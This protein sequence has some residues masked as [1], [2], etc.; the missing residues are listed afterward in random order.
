MNNGNNDNIDNIDDEYE[1]KTINTSFIKQL[2]S[3]NVENSNQDSSNVKKKEKIDNQIIGK[4]LG[5]GS[6]GVVKKRI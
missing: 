5:K 2:D 1:A 3:P 6:F 4:S